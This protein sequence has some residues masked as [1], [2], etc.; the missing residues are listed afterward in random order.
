M[1][2][3]YFSETLDLTAHREYV[4]GDTLRT[5]MYDP[6]KCACHV[7]DGFKRSESY[8]I[9]DW[10]TDM[11]GCVTVKMGVETVQEGPTNYWAA[12]WAAAF[13]TMFTFALSVTVLGVQSRSAKCNAGLMIGAGHAENKRLALKAVRGMGVVVDDDHQAD[14]WL[15]LLATSLPRHRQIRV[16]GKRPGTTKYG[17]EDPDEYYARVKHT[18]SLNALLAL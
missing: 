13:R 9:L 12:A 11:S 5:E 14:A 8:R 2:G 6:V 10:L 1:R 4:S 17:D 16:P 7:V 15:I 18:L 3:G